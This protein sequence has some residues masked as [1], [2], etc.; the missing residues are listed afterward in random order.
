MLMALSTSA[1]TL[2]ELDRLPDD[3]NAYALVSWDLFVTPPPSPAH[4]QLA[5]ALH[6]LI[7]LFVWTHGLGRVYT[8]KVSSARLIRRW[9]RI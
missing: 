6:G 5:S 1:W 3:G 4:E 7:A 2:A 9:S 8:P